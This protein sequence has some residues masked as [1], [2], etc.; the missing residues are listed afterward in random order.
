MQELQE[1]N[2]AGLTDVIISDCDPPVVRISGEDAYF[3]FYHS[4]TVD[5]SDQ[6]GI[7]IALSEPH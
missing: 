3:H 1:Y 4:G 7:T 6:D 2:L 5:A